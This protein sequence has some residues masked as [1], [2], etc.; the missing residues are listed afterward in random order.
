M[1]ENISLLPKVIYIPPRE[2][3]RLGSRWIVY[4][5]QDHNELWEAIKKSGKKVRIYIEVID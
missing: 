4:L 1:G 2:I 5:P 3:V